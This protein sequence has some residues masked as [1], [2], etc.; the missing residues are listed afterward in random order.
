LE[1]QQTIKTPHWVAGLF[2][3]KWF[4]VGLLVS[5]AAFEIF[6]TY[7][8]K[9]NGWFATL[10]WGTQILVIV[11]AASPLLLALYFLS[12]KTFRLSS[13]FVALTMVGVFLALV[14]QPVLREQKA[15]A[16]SLKFF[17]NDIQAGADT[18]HVFEG[19]TDGKFQGWR[20]SDGV[21]LQRQR[22]R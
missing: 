20:P 9:T 18:W 11:M 16:A 10:D 6:L 17:A 22:A 4:R 12:G 1:T 3:R 21:L 5:V 8:L 13:V 2:Y 19:S 14:I 15:R 7:F